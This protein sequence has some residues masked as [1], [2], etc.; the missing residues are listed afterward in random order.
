MNSS[1]LSRRVGA[2][3]VASA[4]AIA[5][6]GCASGGDDTAEQS[7]DDAITTL[8]PGTL[9]VATGEPAYTPWVE[10]DDPASGEGFEAA[11]AYAVA[12]E[13]GFADDEVEWVRASFETSVTPGP[14]DWDLN[15]QQFSVTDERKNAVD[16]SSTYY[17]TSQ[18]VIA[19]ADSPAADV[20]SVAELDEYKVGASVGST[21]YALADAE[22]EQEVAT[23]NS[24]EDAVLALS[25]G[26]IDAFVI[27]LP[28]A[29]YLTGAEIDGGVIIGQFADTSGGDEL[30]FVLPKDS[31]LR[32]APSRTPVDALREDG[33]LAEAFEQE[34]A[35]LTQ[36]TCPF[37][38]DPDEQPRPRDG[39]IRATQRA[40]TRPSCR[41]QARHGAQ[42][43][44]RPGQ[45]RCRRGRARHRDR[46]HPRL[47]H[48]PRNVLLSRSRRARLPRRSAGLWLNVRVLFFAAIA[49]AVLGTLLAV[50]RSLRGPVFFPLRALATIYVDFFRGVPVLIVLYLVGLGI[51]TLGI[52]PAHRRRGARNRRD[53]AVLFRVRRRGAG[54][55]HGG[56]ASLTAHRG[57]LARAVARADA[58]HGRR[59]A[60]RAQG[61][62]SSD[63]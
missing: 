31:E 25:S 14:K 9:T 10:D 48:R 12:E 51:P 45:H 21:S 43:A 41:A 24:N 52:F 19:T 35:P 44:D 15:L 20:G 32:P 33:T 40:R 53:H 47:G 60:G 38:T 23:F 39:P 61:R 30:A 4:A 58:A 5:L 17:T 16:F 27:D 11:V 50:M 29:F 57:A 36:S 54:A 7:G 1:S 42:R 18:A 55:G 22:L 3:A 46:Q 34:W 13:L 56:G 63:E 49:V 59:P 8:T 62:S 6:A 2:V 28:S 37:S 26:Q